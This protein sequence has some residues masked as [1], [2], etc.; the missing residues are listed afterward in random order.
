MKSRNKK[1]DGVVRRVQPQTKHEE[2]MRHGNNQDTVMMKVPDVETLLN[3]RGQTRTRYFPD[4]YTVISSGIINDEDLSK[5]RWTRELLAVK[6]FGPEYHI[7]TDYPYYG[8]M[9]EK[10]RKANLRKMM[11]GAKWMAQQLSNTE[12]KVIPLIKGYS[13]EERSICYEAIREISPK[14]CAIYGSQ[15]FG[16]SMGNGINKLNRHVREIVS[17]VGIE[18]ILLIGPQYKKGVEK[19][20]PEVKATAGQSSWIKKSKLREVPIPVAH[21]RYLDWKS[22]IES[23]LGR[24]QATI[25]SAIRHS[26]GVAAPG[27]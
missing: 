2:F 26:S 18:N 19:L 23:A 8:D 22:E 5:L 21:S 20:P 24:G 3:A 14:Y 7:P 25:K 27:S 4:N 11:S 10:E 9:P 15:Y 6:C 13:P 16:G 1:I 12:T 17:E